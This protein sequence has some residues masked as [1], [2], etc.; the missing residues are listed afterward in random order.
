MKYW[1]KLALRGS[2]DDQLSLGQDISV[3]VWLAEW[4][5]SLIGF[6][7][8][9]DPTILLELNNFDIDA[10]L[11]LGVH[12]ILYSGDQLP[13]PHGNR[14]YGIHAWLLINIAGLIKGGALIKTEKLREV[15]YHGDQWSFS[16]L[17]TFYVI[18]SRKYFFFFEKRTRTLGLSKS[19]YWAIQR[20]NETGHRPSRLRT[21]LNATKPEVSAEPPVWHVFSL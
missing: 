8:R 16:N 18:G 12:D 2:S 11:C 14:L 21:E 5:S 7:V 4:H 20:S 10:S 3:I 19:C 13:R 17:P 15:V 1:L 9:T 6:N